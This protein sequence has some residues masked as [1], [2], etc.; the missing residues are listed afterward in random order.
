MPSRTCGNVAATH[1]LATDGGPSNTVLLWDLA[2]GQKLRTLVGH[3]GW[4]FRA[5]FSRDGRQLATSSPWDPVARIWDVATGREWRQLEHPDG[6]PSVAY[7]PDGKRLVTTCWDGK[8][9]VWDTE[10]WTLVDE[11]PPYGDHAYCAEFS[12]DGRRIAYAGGYY[13]WANS[14]VTSVRIWDIESREVRSLEGHTRCV[15]G[16]AWNPKGDLLASCGWD[17]QVILWDVASGLPLKRLEPGARSR[18]LLQMSFSPEGH[19]LAVAGSEFPAHPY[20]QVVSVPTLRVLHDLAGHSKNVHGLSFSRDGQYIATAAMDGMVKVWSAEPLPPYLSLEGH[21]Q[22]V[23]AVAFSPNGDFVATGSL[24]Q[25]AKI[26]DAKS[27]AL[28]QNLNVCFPVVSLAF[29][30]GGKRLVTVGPDN[31]ACVWKV[32]ASH[33]ADD[34]PPG[35]GV[36]QSSAALVAGPSYEREAAEKAPENWRTP[37]RLQ[38]H[39]AAVMAVAW[40]PDDRWLLTASKDKSARIWDATTGALQRTLVGHRD[41]VLAAVFAPNS[42]LVAT[43][44]ADDVIRLWDTRSGQCLRT[45]TNHQGDVLSLAFS[46]DGNLL[47]SGGADQKAWIW[48]V[49]SG[50]QLQELSASA[51]GVTSVA[52]SPNGTRLATANSGTDLYALV[53]RESRIRL[54]DVS[55]GRELLSLV[56]HSNTVYGVAFSPDGMRFATGSGDNTARIWTAFPWRSEDYPGQPELSLSARIENYKRQFSRAALET[57]R[58]G[59]NFRTEAQLPRHTSVHVVGSFNLPPAGSKTSPRRPILPRSPLAGPDQLDLTPY[60]NVALNESWQPVESLGEVDLSLAALPSG[61]RTFAGVRFDVRGLIQ[62]RR[63]AVDCELF[64]ERVAIPVRRWFTQLHLLH[65]GRWEEQQGT[66]VASLVLHYADGTEA[67]LP[68][69]YGEHLHAANAG[70]DRKADCP[71]GQLVWPSPVP[72]EPE[73]VQPWLYQTTFANP[74]P[75]LEVERIEYVSKVGRCGPFLVAVTVE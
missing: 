73:E 18:G 68:I 48:D 39:T 14:R 3:G 28:L 64:P 46:P 33:K 25:T 27:G 22:P 30:R 65:G 69:V 32:E 15:A 11:S 62:L 16:V 71:L 19:S 53:N 41:W 58:H 56:A 52:F 67:T 29:S 37:R 1:I 63:G 44:S 8:V 36:Q 6:V 45:L 20:A 70:A 51:N 47:A 75:A 2:A 59:Q 10:R 13:I 54:W 35:F 38:G 74:R 17:G 50:H 9:R 34:S 43:G 66:A 12:P 61:L 4:V 57:H 26:W 72:A 42:Q 5:A 24:D 40:S 60:Y 23:W 7:S 31:S 49:E 21:D 55:L